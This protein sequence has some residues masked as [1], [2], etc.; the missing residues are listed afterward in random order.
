VNASSTSR[1]LDFLL[2]PVQQIE[3]DAVGLQP[4]QAALAGR[5]RAASRRVFGQHLADE[6]DLLAPARDRRPDDFLRPAVAVHFRGVDQRHAEIETQPQRRDLLA[7]PPAVLAHRPGAPPERRHALAARKLRGRDRLHE[8][9][10]S[11]RAFPLS[12]CGR[13]WRVASIGEQR[14]G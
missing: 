9:H 14:A 5:D 1:K 10:P 3:I 6:E 11:W 13:G 2:A 8:T 12:P 7:A 4:S